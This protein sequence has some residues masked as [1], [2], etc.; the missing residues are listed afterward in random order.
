MAGRALLL[1]SAS[2]RRRELLAQLG[3]DFE[4]CPADIDETP[5][6]GEAAAD[7]V[8]RMA[9][10]KAAAVAGSLQSGDRLVLGADTSVVVDGDILGKPEDRDHG[11]RL[12]RRL[13]GR[14]HR[15][16][17][18]LALWGRELE[19]S[20]TVCTEVEFVPLTESVCRAYLA[21]GESWDK[22][23]GYAIQGAGGA[24]VS[25]I[26]GSYSNVVGL[27]LAETWGLLESCGVETGLHVPG[28]LE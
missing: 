24:L 5:L 12:L 11:L 22:A 2:P 25:R 17:T 27:P 23:G 19:A 10:E 20:R 28:E 1:A 9:L 26:D 3:L 14:R 21:L 13:S 16:M 8:E 4:V 6:S 15:V 18:A 7:Y